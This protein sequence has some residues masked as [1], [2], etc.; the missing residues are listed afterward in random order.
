M[1]VVIFSLP[2]IHERM[3]RTWGANSGPLA[4]QAQHL[5]IELPCPAISGLYFGSY[6]GLNAMKCCLD[7]KRISPYDQQ[8]S[9][10]KLKDRRASCYSGASPVLQYAIT[11]KG[12]IVKPI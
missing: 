11:P 7:Y 9:F 4:C 5:P 1:A 2:S 12:N 10:P 8:D 6:N 3:R